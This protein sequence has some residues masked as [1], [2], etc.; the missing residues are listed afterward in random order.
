MVNER[1]MVI[2]GDDDGV[3]VEMKSLF[4]R[5]VLGEK[6]RNKSTDQPG[7][8]PSNLN[9]DSCVRLIDIQPQ[10]QPFYQSHSPLWPSG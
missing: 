4:R 8:S 5:G 10:N 3:A 2:N 7:Q 6:G 1:I 9:I